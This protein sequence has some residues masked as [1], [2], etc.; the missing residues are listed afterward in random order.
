MDAG[1]IRDI[2]TADLIR[3]SRSDPAQAPAPPPLDG[4]DRASPAVTTDISDHA[5]RL[6][7][8]AAA[9]GTEVQQYDRDP[10]TKTLVYKAIDSATGQVLVQ[11]PDESML[12]MRAYLQSLQPQVT[13]ST[14]A[15]SA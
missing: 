7:S 9:D 11:L 14:L 5:E 8:L 13:E 3:T 15:K 4:A 10:D 6:R 1:A 2:Y 12:R